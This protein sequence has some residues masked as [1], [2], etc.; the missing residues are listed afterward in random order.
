MSLGC[1][2]KQ[3]RQVLYKGVDITDKI[4]LCIC[5]QC[6]ESIRSE[7]DAL[8]KAKELA[9]TDSQQLKASIALAY[10]FAESCTDSKANGTMHSFVEWLEQQAAV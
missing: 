6:T 2:N 10:K 7:I 3:H 4:G 8:L 1:W 9:A 5:D